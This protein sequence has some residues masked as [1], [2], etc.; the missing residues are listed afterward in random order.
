MGTHELPTPTEPAADLV[1]IVARI[2]CHARPDVF[3][4][5]F[6]IKRCHTDCVGGPGPDDG[7]AQEGARDILAAL[8]DR[9][10]PPGHVAVPVEDL[11]VALTLA[12]DSSPSVASSKALN[13]LCDAIA[14]ARLSAT[15]EEKAR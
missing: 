13:R 11:H 12:A 15:S 9:L 5:S 10:L 6:C 1:E 8:S 3:K 14:A 2:V 7:W 4:T